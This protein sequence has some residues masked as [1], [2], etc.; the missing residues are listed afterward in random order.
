MKSFLGKCTL[1][2][3]LSGSVG[4]CVH[5]PGSQPVSPISPGGDA[6]KMLRI[7]GGDDG[8]S[9]VDFVSLPRTGGEP[10]QSVQSRLYTTDVEIFD[11]LPGA[12]IDWHRVST[13]RFLI[14]L[15][16][17]LEIGLGDGTTYLM[18][19][20]D[21]ALAADTTGRGHTSRTIG[22][23]PVRIMTVRLPKDDSLTPKL[24][25]CP[26]GMDRADCVTAQMTE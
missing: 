23:E 24:D 11:S 9:R 15:S 5:G 22:D 16:G 21:I 2:L 20:G 13:P 12:F 1:L 18:R 25:S 3:V 10:G 14:V 6:L 19:K 4:G 26:E 17:Q 7:Y 8:E